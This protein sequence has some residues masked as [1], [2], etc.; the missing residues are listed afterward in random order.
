MYEITDKIEESFW[1]NGPEVVKMTF[2][3]N[4]PEV[5]EV[6]EDVAYYKNGLY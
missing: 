3:T 2:W 4:C 5:E 1:T 6:Y